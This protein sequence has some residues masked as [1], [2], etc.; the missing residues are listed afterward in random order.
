MT[1]HKSTFIKR[2]VA[3]VCAPLAVAAALAP[4]VLGTAHAEQ[5][6]GLTYRSA[7]IPGF[8]RQSRGLANVP[9]CFCPCNSALI[10][11][12]IRNNLNR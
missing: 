4:L 9:C 12:W 5:I 1:T 8:M 11:T 10:L 2:F 3:K 7:P 6:P